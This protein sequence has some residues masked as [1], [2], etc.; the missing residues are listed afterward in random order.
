[1]TWLAVFTRAVIWPA[2]RRASG[3]WIGAVVIGGLA[4]GGNGMS[5]R[6]VTTLATNNLA[7]GAVLATTWLLV[8]LPVARILVRAEAAAY[9]RSLPAPR[10]TPALAVVAALV[11]FQLPWLVLWMLGDPAHGLVVVGGLTI[12]MVVLA[13]VRPRLLAGTPAWRTS[14]RALTGMFARALVRRAGDALLR[15]TG[16]A[17]LAGCVAG[18]FVRNNGLEGA[19]AATLGACTIAILLVPAHVGPL[20]VL[21]DAHR[22]SAWLAT[23]LGLSPARRTLSLALAIAGVN[24]VACAIA[25]VA[26]AIVAGANPYVALAAIVIA[27][28]SALAATRALAS[29]DSSSPSLSV[30]DGSHTSKVAIRAVTANILVGALAIIAMGILGMAGLAAFVAT[31]I[32]FLLR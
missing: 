17:I 27:I 5:P 24:L 32:L 3:A 25:L 8:F 11:G 4:F 6:D 12:V 7:I 9:L 26:F 30:D 29:A 18:L 23:S 20:V 14:A 10:V 28:G 21:H 31:I 22:A 16:L 13:R 19:G 1:V 2:G 15:A